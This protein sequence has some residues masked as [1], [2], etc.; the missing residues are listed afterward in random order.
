LHLKL[1]LIFHL[2]FSLMVI[3]T[4]PGC[5]VSLETTFADNN[6]AGGNVFDIE[7]SAPLSIFGMHVHLNFV[8]SQQVKVYLKSGAY[9]ATSPHGFVASDLIYDGTVTA[10][11]IG[12]PTE[13]PGFP[14][15]ELAIPGTY[16]FMVSNVQGNVVRYTNGD[17]E[18]NVYA[19]NQGELAIKQGKGCGSGSDILSCTFAPR[20][21]NGRLTYALSGPEGSPEP[22]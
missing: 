4:Q 21:W 9:T 12:N 18:G 3:Q 8:G 20:V 22:R 19:S 14:A 13:L 1:Q 5:E 2:S 6:G 15:Q 17:V 7:V 10:A 11:G 16:S